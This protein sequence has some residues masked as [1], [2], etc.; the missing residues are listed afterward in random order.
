MMMMMIILF[1]RVALQMHVVCR[2]RRHIEE[3]RDGEPH[4]VLVSIMVDLRY[5]AVP[6]DMLRVEETYL[7]VASFAVSSL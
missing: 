7:D 2:R 1:F 4:G 6:Q 3:R 5:L